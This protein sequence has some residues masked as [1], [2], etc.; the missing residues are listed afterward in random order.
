MKQRVLNAKRDSKKVLT[1]QKKPK[2]YRDLR[3]C[4]LFLQHDFVA[5]FFNLLNKTMVYDVKLQAKKETK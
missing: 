1:H 5:L 3:L 4:L 2:L